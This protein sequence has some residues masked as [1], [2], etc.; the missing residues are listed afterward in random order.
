MAEDLHPGTPPSTLPPW[1][2]PWPCAWT[3][4]PFEPADRGALAV[5]RHGDQESEAVEALA[6]ATAG[7]RGAID[8]AIGE[9]LAAMRKRDRLMSLGFSSIGDYAREVLGIGER[10]AQ[11]MA[12]LATELRTRPLLRAAVCAGEVRTRKAETILPVAVG[13]DHPSNLVGLCTAHHLFGIHGG[14]LR[15][16]GKAPDRLVWLLGGR[17]WMGPR[18]AG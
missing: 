6:G 17:V 2:P 7:A 5:L 18:W 13:E 15:V 3:E 14:Y 16:L 10:K 11:G 1:P 9:G 12:H 8:L 4:P